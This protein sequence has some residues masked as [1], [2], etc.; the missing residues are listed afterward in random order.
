MLKQKYTK[1]A[2]E[3][4]SQL[5]QYIVFSYWGYE[6][7]KTSKFLPWFM[8]GQNTGKDAFESTM[9]NNPFCEFPREVYDWFLYSA[10]MYFGELIRH[11]C[12]EERKNDFGEML[13]HHL[14]TVFLVFGSAYANQIGIGAIISWLHF[15]TDIA[16]AMVK[17]LSST[18]F[19]NITVVWFVGV[20]LPSWF[21][22]RLVC[23]PFW[24]FSVF[25][26]PTTVYPS[27]LS[28]FNIFLTLNGLYLCV[29]QILQI[30]WFCLF[31]G[32]L[33]KYSTTGSTEDT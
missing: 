19:E 10:G 31:L 28:E 4:V 5:I 9:V 32:M 1:K 27:H 15:V 33:F 21:Y 17:L 22:F 18:H 24:I 7:L 12:W 2:T 3:N 11:V 25:T 14:A 16:V 30:Y 8:G 13:I 26:S 23:L 20:H 6:V 29:L